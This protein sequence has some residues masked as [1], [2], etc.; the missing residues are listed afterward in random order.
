MIKTSCCGYARV[1]ALNAVNAGLKSQLPSGQHLGSPKVPKPERVA[2]VN[3]QAL[4]RLQG[5]RTEYHVKEWGSNARDREV[6]D[7]QPAWIWDE[8]SSQATR[9]DLKRVDRASNAC[10]ASGAGWLLSPS[11][12]RIVAR[13]G[14]ISNK[15]GMSGKDCRFIGRGVACFKRGNARNRWSPTGGRVEASKFFQIRSG[16]MSNLGSQ[17]G[18]IWT[19]LNYLHFKVETL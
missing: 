12:D 13:R 4:T 18:A 14:L 3:K 5:L 7:E 6:G 1:L 9:W 17:L 15:L 11:V 8:V 16:M 2:L 19:A 10:S